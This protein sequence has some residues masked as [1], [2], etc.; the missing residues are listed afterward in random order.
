MK[1][2]VIATILLYKLFLTSYMHCCAAFAVV[3]LDRLPQRHSLGE[4]WCMLVHN[5]PQSLVI[6][7]ESGLGV[8]RWCLKLF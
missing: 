4:K 6:T 5:V 7:A 1:N 2:D 3:P 8:E